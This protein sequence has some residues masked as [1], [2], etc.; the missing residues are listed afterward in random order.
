MNR[1]EVCPI[2][3]KDVTL[4]HDYVEINATIN[5]T[6]QY[7]ASSQSE[8]QLYAHKRCFEKLS[9]GGVRLSDSSNDD[10]DGDPAPDLV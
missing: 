10:S 2:C 5:A 7:A 4:N 6:N 9:D 8:E 1:T 3:H